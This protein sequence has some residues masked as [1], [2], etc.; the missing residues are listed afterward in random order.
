MPYRSHPIRFVHA[1]VM[2]T[3]AK[4]FGQALEEEKEEK[5]QDTAPAG[6]RFHFFILDLFG[7]AKQ[8]TTLCCWEPLFPRTHTLT[9]SDIHRHTTLSFR[10]SGNG[11]VVL[12]KLED[13]SIYDIVPGTL[14]KEAR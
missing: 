8:A 4:G 9:H 14:V 1:D 12:F 6:Y 10:A 13:V 2:L 7:S 5:A 3:C 11:V